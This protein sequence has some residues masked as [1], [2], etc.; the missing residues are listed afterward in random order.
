MRD[1]WLVLVLP[2]VFLCSS[3]E[4]SKEEEDPYIARYK[5]SRLYISDIADQ[6]QNMK[7]NDSIEY[8]KSYAEQ[9]LKERILLELAEK[10]LISE[11]KDITKDVEHYRN[12]LLIYKYHQEYI[13]QNLDTTVSRQELEEYYQNHFNE[14]FLEENIIQALFI[15]LPK[16]A[17]R[18]DFVKRFYQSEKPKDIEKLDDYCNKNA[19][20]YDDFRNKWVSFARVQKYLP[21]MVTEQENFLRTSRFV[22]MADSNFF[23][24]LKIKAYKIKGE[25]APFEFAADMIKPAII[26]KR[27]N[28]ILKNLETSVFMDAVQNKDAEILLK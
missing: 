2:I 7:G 11:Q 25:H 21:D 27:K 15:Q 13:R 26:N 16:S 24:F 8:I 23:Y 6:L 10:N 4:L 5:S 28:E 12:S 14:Y 1:S 19:Y 17:P 9:W 22:E 20:K 18:S 3:C